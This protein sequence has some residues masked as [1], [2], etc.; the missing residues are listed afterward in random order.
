MTGTVPARLRDEVRER[1]GVGPRFAEAYLGYWAAARGRRYESLA[2]ILDAPL[3][4]PMWFDFAM[5]A[6]WRGERFAEALRPH[7]PAGARRYLDVGCGFGGSLVAFARLGL[8]VVGI[9]PAPERV[10]LTRA[11][12]ADEGIGDR[13]HEVGILAPDLVERLGVFDLVTCIDVIEHVDDV[14]ATIGR[15]VELLRPGGLLAL[16]IP[17]AECPAFVARDGHFGL[18]G[19]TLLDREDA[20]L[21]QRANLDG[22]YDVGEYHPLP[23]YERRFAA[24]GCSS[25]LL[26]PAAS[27]PEA[28]PRLASL[29]AGYVRSRPSRAALPPALRARLARRLASYL[30]GLALR[31]AAATVSAARRQAFARRY[32]P[33][34]WTLLVRRAS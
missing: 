27:R 1:Y 22:P 3:P 33:E 16:E 30:A 29:L 12:L 15:L 24:L 8:D 34:F 11:N 18:F 17:N 19:I 23:Y 28:A 2:E 7:L 26:D 32:G 4:E 6:N 5:S 21:Y 14:P 10:E 20:R 13:V 31:R 25:E 9:E